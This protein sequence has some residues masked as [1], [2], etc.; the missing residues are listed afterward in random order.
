MDNE[1]KKNLPTST[2]TYL[3]V[4]TGN[5]NSVKISALDLSDPAVVA[6]Y[7]DQG[8]GDAIAGSR[9]KTSYE[10]LFKELSASIKLHLNLMEKTPVVQSKEDQQDI[11][12]K[13][14]PP[15]IKFHASDTQNIQ[16]TNIVSTDPSLSFTFLM[17]REIEKSNAKALGNYT[18]SINL[19]KVGNMYKQLD[20]VST[21]DYIKNGEPLNVVKKDSQGKVAAN[22]DVKLAFQAEVTEV[23]AIVKNVLNINF[24]ECNV[25]KVATDKFQTD[26]CSTHISQAA[27]EFFLDFLTCNEIFNLVSVTQYCPDRDTLVAGLEFNWL[28]A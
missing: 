22:Q 28:D 17:L 19:G 10:R 24:E 11:F 1:E 15:E 8:A 21:F 13:F 18:I 14:V 27:P 23:T 2:G 7:R 12:M 5:E 9:V 4:Y 3:K 16:S 26:A 6:K 20:V 25:L